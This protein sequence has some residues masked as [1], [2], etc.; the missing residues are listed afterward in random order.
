MLLISNCDNDDLYS[1][2]TLTTLA[3]CARL[4]DDILNL[5]VMPSRVSQVCLSA[6]ERGYLDRVAA[7]I[8]NLITKK[9]S[10]C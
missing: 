6:R 1:T 3:I 9:I 2:F 4:C 8:E 10:A 5:D 7:S